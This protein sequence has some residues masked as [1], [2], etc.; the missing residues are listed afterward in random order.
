[1]KIITGCN[2]LNKI[3]PDLFDLAVASVSVQYNGTTD[4][5]DFYVH[6]CNALY[7]QLTSIVADTDANIADSVFAEGG[8]DLAELFRIQEQSE[9]GEQILRY[10]TTGKSLL[11]RISP[12]ESESLQFV[13][14]DYTLVNRQLRSFSM[15]K[16]GYQK[17]IENF[18]GMAFQRMLKPEIKS[19]FTAGAYEEITGYTSEQAKDFLSW[20]EIVHPDDQ[21][22]IR[23]GGFELYDRPGIKMDLEY[24]I[25]RKDGEIRWIHSYD[26]HFLS[27]DGNMQMVQGLI[28]D[29]TEL[30]KQE[31]E[32]QEANNKIREQNE[33]LEEMTM[34]DHLTGLSNRRAMHQ[35]L[36]YLIDDFKRT[37]ESFCIL[38]IDLDNFKQINDRLGHDA[39]DT[40]L[41]GISRIFNESLRKID[42]KA[43]WGGEEFL[44]SLP[45]TDTENGLIIGEKLLETVRNTVFEHNNIDIK[46]TFS[47]GLATYNRKISMEIL[48]KE[49]DRALY[50][51]KEAGKNKICTV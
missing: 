41:C 49:A 29:V 36:D 44:I 39:G 9:K 50:K 20:L 37:K 23:Q 40:V 7:S 42:F 34:T 45:R 3:D 4:L 5:Y 31:L 6:E 26:N 17:Y 24:R 2:N 51:A 11:T 32:L 22:K 8:V 13:C 15:Q 30:K 43:R 46:M 38:M 48:I 19:V 21:E 25:I 27:E 28:I 10:I 33:K 1:M 16:I 12:G 35:V 14:I 47:G 18:H